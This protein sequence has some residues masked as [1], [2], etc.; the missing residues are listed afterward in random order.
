MGGNLGSC[1]YATT[2]AFNNG[3]CNNLAGLTATSTPALPSGVTAGG[4][5]TILGTTNGGFT[6]TQMA[7]HPSPTRLDP[8]AACSQAAGGA[9]R[10]T[11]TLSEVA[12]AHSR[13][14]AL[15]PISDLPGVHDAGQR[16]RVLL[17]RDQLARQ[18]PQGGL[19]L[20][21]RLHARVFLL[22]AGLPGPPPE[23]EPPLDPCA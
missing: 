17:R 10:K 1:N 21:R 4:Y 16:A 18:Q 19:N 9:R 7:R 23:P 14:A 13:G 3:G 5:G 8:R 22:Y 12:G 6:W 2:G 15:L 20:G 11:P